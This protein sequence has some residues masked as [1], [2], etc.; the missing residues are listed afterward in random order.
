MPPEHE[1]DGSNPPGR[2]IYKIIQSRNSHN[3]A[4]VGLSPF[5]VKGR[6][7]SQME[8]LRFFSGR[9]EAYDMGMDDL[10]EPALP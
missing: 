6:G 9:L 4:P 2:T 8:H 3:F 10:M 1:V 7:F 5:R